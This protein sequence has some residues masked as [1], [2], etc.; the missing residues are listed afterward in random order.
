V[1]AMPPKKTPN[2]TL[3]VNKN[4]PETRCI[5]G[6]G[7]FPASVKPEAHWPIPFPH[8]FL[9]ALFRLPEY[10]NKPLS[11]PFTQ[12]WIETWTRISSAISKQSQDKCTKF[13]VGH[14]C[15]ALRELAERGCDPNLVLS[16]F[17]QYLWDE[18]VPSF[19]RK[20]PNL[21]AHLEDLKAVQLTRRLFQNHTWE[22]TDETE[23]IKNALSQ[24]EDIV[25]S[26]IGDLDF[27]SGRH[28]QNDK[29]NRVICAIY[30]H[31][32]QRSVGPQWRLFLDLLFAAGVISISHSTG[33]DHPDRRI[34]PRIEVFKREHPKEARSMPNWV[35]SW[36]LSSIP[37][38]VL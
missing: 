15:D 33:N 23:L 24:L 30:H 17:V 34:M 6:F 38:S 37:S 28:S 25:Q 32:T 11:S 16:L 7:K 29:Q 3:I 20:D 8:Q 9:T 27:H 31:L 22:R 21:Q 5:P 10:R 36:P 14:G 18:R 13:F 19:E 2:P 26:Y 1:R 35:K 4:P 12:S